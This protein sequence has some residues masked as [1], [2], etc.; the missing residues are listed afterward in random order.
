MATGDNGSLVSAG[1]ELLT[2]LR[3]DGFD[4]VA[5]RQGAQKINELLDRAAGI[6]TLRPNALVPP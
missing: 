5:A 6:T 3:T 4:P 1:Q 2:L